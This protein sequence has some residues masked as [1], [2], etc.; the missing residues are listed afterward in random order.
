MTTSQFGPD[1]YEFAKDKNITLM[2]GNNL[3]H[4]FERHGYA[5][6]IDLA[7]ARQLANNGVTG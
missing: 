4:L 1:A 6:R 7:E 3:L 2:D 5:F